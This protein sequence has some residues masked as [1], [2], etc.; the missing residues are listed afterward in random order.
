[1]LMFLYTLYPL[2]D[3]CWHHANPLT[4]IRVMLEIFKPSYLNLINVDVFV[5]LLE[6]LHSNFH[7]IDLESTSKSVSEWV[8]GRNSTVTVRDVWNNP[9]K[10]KNPFK[11]IISCLGEWC[12]ETI[13]GQIKVANLQTIH[14]GLTRLP[15]SNLLSKSHHQVSFGF[16]MPLDIKMIVQVLALS[17][18]CDLEWRSRQLKL[19]SNCGV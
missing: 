11:T 14:T 10:K 8:N 12:A 15:C 1:M 19:V 4:S 18:S 16:F 5:S 9:R 7:G 17:Y 13:L 6:I 2:C 3:L